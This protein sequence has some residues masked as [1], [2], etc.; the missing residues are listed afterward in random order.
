MGDKLDLNVG[1]SRQGLHLDGRAGRAIAREVF[2]IDLIHGGKIPEVREKN[3]RFY[4]VRKSQLLIL[5][6]QLDV[7]HDPFGLGA[8][9][10]GDQMSG[11]GDDG[12]LAGGEEKVVHSHRVAVGPDWRGRF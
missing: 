2:P 5:K 8:D 11:F 10:T 9:V 3:H 7:F 12:D 1:P 6:D 4:D